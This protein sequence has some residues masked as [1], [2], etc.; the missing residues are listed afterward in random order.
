[1]DKK[2]RKTGLGKGIPND[3]NNESNFQ[4]TGARY[5]GHTPLVD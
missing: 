3:I 5:Q 4:T 2:K 1:M